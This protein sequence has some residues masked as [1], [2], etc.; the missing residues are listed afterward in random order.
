[1][2]IE[3]TKWRLKLYFIIPL[4][5]FVLAYYFVVN[6]ILY[7]TTNDIIN[8][9]L[10]ISAI[11]LLWKPLIPFFLVNDRRIVIAPQWMLRFKQ[12]TGQLESV[13]LTQLRDNGQ[14]YRKI[15]LVVYEAD[16]P[17]CG[18]KVNIFQ[19]KREFKGRLI[20]ECTE[21]PREH[22]FSFD[23]IT[24]TGSKLR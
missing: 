4:L 9:T 7:P 8:L 2:S 16:C 20:G 13:K 21:S 10:F 15:I 3:L 5:L 6:S 22:I 24:Q 14:P 17:I 18:N 23:H 1:M 11:F 19:G 12:L